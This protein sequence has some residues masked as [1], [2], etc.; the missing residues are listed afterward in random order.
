MDFP[1]DALLDIIVIPMIFVLILLSPYI[2]GAFIGQVIKLFR[3]LFSE[4]DDDI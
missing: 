1:W 2:L 3:N 4:K